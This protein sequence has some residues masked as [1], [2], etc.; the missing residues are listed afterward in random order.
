VKEQVCEYFCIKIK[1]TQNNY[2]I[3]TQLTG[4]PFALLKMEY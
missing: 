2:Q 1:F 4:N 3:F